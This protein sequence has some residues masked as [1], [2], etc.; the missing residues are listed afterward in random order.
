V[1]KKQQN[2]PPGLIR[3]VDTK[4]IRTIKRDGGK[5]LLFSSFSLTFFLGLVFI[6]ATTLPSQAANVNVSADVAGCGNSITEPGEACDDG[7]LTSEFCGD[8]TVQSG[9]FCDANCLNPINLNEA[10]EIDSDC[11]SG[12]SCNNCVCG[13]GGAGPPPPPPVCI[14]TLGCGVTSYG[15]CINGTKIG[16]GVNNCGSGCSAPA[17]CQECGNTFTEGTEECDDGNT[18]AGDGCASNCLLETG[19]GNGVI[20]PGEECDDNNTANN[21]CCSS[22]CKVQVVVAATVGTL[23]NNSANIAWTTNSWTGSACGI[24]STDSTIE[25]G[26][27]PSVG[28]GV[29]ALA[30][31]NYNYQITNLTL[32]QPYNFR[33]TA[34]YASGPINANGQATGSFVTTGGVEDCLN[35]QDDDF[36]GLIDIADSDCPCSAE[37]TCTPSNWDEVECLEN[38]QTRRCNKTNDCW[39]DVPLPEVQRACD[40][41]C[42]GITCPPFF[43]LDEN[44]CGCVPLPAECGNGICEPLSEDPVSCAQDCPVECLSDWNCN[45]WNPTS[46]PASGVQ[47]RDCFDLNA[48]VIPINKPAIT[49]TCG[50]TCQG[51]SCGSCQAINT[52]SCTCEESI[53]CCGNGICETG[54]N[55]AACNQDCIVQCIPNWTCSGW[56]ECSGGTQSRQCQDLNNCNLNLDRPPEIR[57]CGGECDV[58]CSACEQINISSCSCAPTVPCCGNSICETSETIWSCGVDCGLPPDFRF[59]L[60]QCLDGLDN[61]NDLIADFP[62][63]IGCRMPQDNSELNIAEVIE[64]V[65]EFIQEKIVDQILDNP[66]IEI[67]NETFATPILVTTVAVNTFSSF[68]FFNFLNYAK[69]FTGQPFFLLFRRK[70]RKWGVVYNSLT[71][72]PVDLAIVRLYQKDDGRIIQSRVTDKMGRYS[73]L[74]PPGRYYITVT[75]PKHAF[76]SVYLKDKKE[77]S[78]YLDLYYGQ[79]IEVTDQKADIT[80]N[81][82]TDSEMEE[83]PDKKII[84]G[85]YLRKVQTAAAF[86]AIPLAATSM[87]ISP[88][89]LTFS[90]FGVHCGLYVLFRRLGYQKPPKSWGIIYDQKDKNPLS[91]SITRIYDK[92]Y[93][94]LLETRVTDGRGRYSFLVDNNVYYVTAEK[95]GYKQTKTSDIDLESKDQEAVVGMDIGLEKGAKEVAM[96]PATLAE[97]ENLTTPMKPPA[98]KVEIPAALPEPPAPER[99]AEPTLEEKVE[100]IEDLGVGKESLEELTQAKEEIDD[101]KEDIEEQKEELE[102]IEDKVEDIEENI[103]QK[104]AQLDEDAES[105]K[106]EQRN[107]KSAQPPSKESTNQEDQKDKKEGQDQS[108]SKDKEDTKPPEKS[109]FG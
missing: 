29:A 58:A 2:K 76:P 14:P 82:P 52:T 23:S 62:D 10:C 40:G 94:K 95:F 86:S 105:Q 99:E 32:N 19:C 89:L 36:D 27:T 26:T 35:G 103:D 20:E 42:V 84:I 45:D 28:D 69:F 18:T 104:L 81:I 78:K 30:G 70:R 63:D 96:A 91:R 59:A 47:T 88:G 31:S 33:I 85:H 24:V 93:N 57:A 66:Q 41:P 107:N 87:L 55:N 80:V 75:K 1:P 109:I 34:N 83:K 100:D 98:T 90:L 77:D 51:L 7:N 61:D 106:T 37:W 3:R 68:S 71:K 64:N 53:P 56:D 6:F 38:I 17:A 9:S 79:T 74:A 12:T 97:P 60:S 48:C 4:P 8:G 11:S 54:E 50:G 101:V 72:R 22:S 44:T 102:K 13:S 5:L 73:F 92:E 15:P 49:Q 46:C 21:D 67:V 16:N 39:S 65:G 108:G 43:Q 25:W